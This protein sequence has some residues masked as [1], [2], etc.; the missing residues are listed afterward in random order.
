VIPVGLLLDRCNG[1]ALALRFDAPEPLD[2]FALRGSRPLG[3]G[4]SLLEA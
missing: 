1:S 3:I 2:R 4:S